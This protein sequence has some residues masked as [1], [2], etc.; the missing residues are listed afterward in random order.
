MNQ[1]VMSREIRG[2]MPTCHVANGGPD[3]RTLGHQQIGVSITD[4]SAAIDR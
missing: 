4:Q 3:P 1:M 2:A